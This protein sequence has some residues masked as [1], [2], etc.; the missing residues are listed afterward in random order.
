MRK[1]PSFLVLLVLVLGINALYAGLGIGWEDTAKPYK[2]LY[3]Q[4]YTVT[5]PPEGHAFPI[6]GHGT[7][8][9]DSSIGSAAVDMGLLTYARGGTVTIEIQEG[10][11]YT[12][13][14]DSYEGWNTVF[15]F[16]DDQLHPILGDSTPVLTIDT[17]E[18]AWQP[19][20][21]PLSFAVR[22][23]TGTSLTYLDIYTNDMLAVDEVGHNLLKQPLENLANTP[24]FFSDEPELSEA[25]LSRYGQMF[26]VQAI[27][28]TGT[29][30]Y[31]TWEPDQ[32]DRVLVLGPEH[33]IARLESSDS[34]L[35]IMNN[36]GYAIFDL[37][38][39]TPQMEADLDF[40]RQLLDVWSLDDGMY[41][42]IDL[43]SWPYLED[44]L[45]TFSEDGLLIVA[46]DEDDYVL[47]KSWYPH[48][49]SWTVELT[50]DDYLW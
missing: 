7:Y 1:H 12:K 16:L 34:Y 20:A 35:R 37:Y 47:V 15:V 36:T 11:D 24:I 26:H 44:F 45:S 40:S 9:W 25:M 38:L 46:Y 32:T 14:S 21:Q 31:R 29:K 13:I 43:A 41:T 4:R 17:D 27:D 49:D 3:G 42:D 22:N 8:S 30:L 19:K 48:E 33:R 2:T 28:S 50:V 23:E 6:H 39:L 18:Q 10:P 5:L